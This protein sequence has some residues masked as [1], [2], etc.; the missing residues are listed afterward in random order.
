MVAG[1]TRRPSGDDEDADGGDDEDEDADGDDEDEDAGRD[2]EHVEQPPLPK[3]L[4]K[5]VCGIQAV[6]PPVYS[7]LIS[8]CYTWSEQASLASECLPLK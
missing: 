6:L 5:Q 4:K 8:I 2:D 1:W 3:R 7:K